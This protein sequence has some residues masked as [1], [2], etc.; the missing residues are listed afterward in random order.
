[1]F[2]LFPAKI[3]SSHF[4]Q[5][6]IDLGGSFLLLKHHSLFNL[7][8]QVFPEHIWSSLVY[9][10]VDIWN[11]QEC[12]NYLIQS[13]GRPSP[14]I[15]DH[16]QKNLASNSDHLLLQLLSQAFPKYN[17]KNNNFSSKKSQFMLKECLVMIFPKEGKK[18]DFSQF[19]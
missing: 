12:A 16:L 7:L 6:I 18:G 4:S 1:M 5:Q 10:H 8:S 11:D 17:W 3:Y 19:F 15:L 2:L 9:G 14:Q 13:L